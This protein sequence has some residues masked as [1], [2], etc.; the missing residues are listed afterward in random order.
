LELNYIQSV[1]ADS[2]LIRA[3][4]LGMDEDGWTDAVMEKAELLLP[5][6]LEAGYAATDDD[7]NS[8]S[9][10]AEGVGA[11]TRSSGPRIPASF[12][13]AVLLSTPGTLW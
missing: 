8:W 1:D 2:A 3:W 9:F 5:I 10:T 12:V 7:L 13:L 4:E 11:L 6:L